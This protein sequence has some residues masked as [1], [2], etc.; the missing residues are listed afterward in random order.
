M[1]LVPEES[2]MA[3]HWRGARFDPTRWSGVWADVCGTVTGTRFRRHRRGQGPPHYRVVVCVPDVP[4]TCPEGTVTFP[5]AKGELQRSGEQASSSNWPQSS[6]KRAFRTAALMANGHRSGVLHAGT[7]T[8]AL[9]PMQTNGKG[10]RPRGGALPKRRARSGRLVCAHEG[11]SGAGGATRRNELLEI[12]QG[13]AG[14]RCGGQRM[15]DRRS[16]QRGPI[17][18]RVRQKRKRI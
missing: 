2:R 13:K 5:N 11:R 6:A 12:Y 7:S 17:A 14:A 9:V 4:G 8:A 16:A 3:T 15:A 1:A 18:L 10:Q